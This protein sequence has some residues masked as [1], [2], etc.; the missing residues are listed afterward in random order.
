MLRKIA[1][2]DE[3]PVDTTLGR[4]MKEVSQRD[5]VEDDGGDTSVQGGRYGSA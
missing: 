3:I 2:W 1:G 4:I 5:V